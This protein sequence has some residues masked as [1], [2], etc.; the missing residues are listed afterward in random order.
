[1]KKG[2]EERSR[3]YIVFHGD[4][5]Y[6]TEN[7]MQLDA[8]GRILSTRL[9]EEIREERSSVYSIGARPSSSKYP[10]EEYTI[11]IYYGTDP[12][13]VEE[14]KQAVFDEIRGFA[15]NG[16]SGEELAKAKEKMLRERELALRENNFWLNILSNT[17]YLKDGDFSE[18]GSY[19]NIVNNM[20]VES[21]K[22]A[23]HTYFDF[24]N[25][26]SVVLKPAE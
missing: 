6:S 11:A 24:D 23:F 19:E 4:F 14:L 2:Q 5:D 10:D 25:Y 7:A 9:L 12:E 1:V 21:V 8:L 22:E 18:F 15:E 16:P 20:T 17:Y 3:Q 13:K 26:V